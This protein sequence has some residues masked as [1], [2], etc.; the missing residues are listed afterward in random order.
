VT[1]RLPEKAVEVIARLE[2][3]NAGAPPFDELDAVARDGWLGDARGL[4]G[5][6]LPALEEDW[7]ERLLGEKAV[8]AASTAL[9]KH[10]A[11]TGEFA[12]SGMREA[13]EAARAGY[14]LVT[15]SG[16]KRLAALQQ[17]EE[18]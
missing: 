9:E 3:A 15:I 1:P 8:D 12:E 13:L 16:R 4:L 2:V 6:I 11:T 14:P 7:R 10:E 5:E 17:R 18:S